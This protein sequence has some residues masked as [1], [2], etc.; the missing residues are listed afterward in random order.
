[1]DQETE[2]K[3]GNLRAIPWLCLSGKP[4][5]LYDGEDTDMAF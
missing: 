3:A 5:L 4:R 2:E 1:M